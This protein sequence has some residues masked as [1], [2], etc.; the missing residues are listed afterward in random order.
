MFDGFVLKVLRAAPTLGLV[1]GTSCLAVA[2]TSTEPC[3][4][5]VFRVSGLGQPAEILVDKWGVPHIYAR[6]T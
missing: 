6:S 1:A 3:A 4:T 2:S 5:T